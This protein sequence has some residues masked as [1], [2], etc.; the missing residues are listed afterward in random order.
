[1]LALAAALVP[2]AALLFAAGVWV[3]GRA[4]GKRDD[5]RAPAA[6]DGATS[7]AVYSPKV[8]S[9][10]WFLDRQRDNVAALERAC[11]DRGEM[12]DESRSARR[13]LDEQAKP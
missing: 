7:R 12:C 11:A 10:P 1:M 13:W 4:G 2:A 8:L 6:L 3:G 9:D 5:R